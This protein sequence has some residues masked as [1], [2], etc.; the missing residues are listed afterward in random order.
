[1]YACKPKFG[2]S[3]AGPFRFFFS[4]PFSFPFPLP[5]YFRYFSLFMSFLSALKKIMLI[6]NKAWKWGHDQFQVLLPILPPILHQKRIRF[7]LDYL[8]QNAVDVQNRYSRAK[9]YILALLTAYQ[10]FSSERIKYALFSW[11]GFHEQHYT[12][13]VCYISSLRHV[14][15]FL[16]FFLLSEKANTHR[17]W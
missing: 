8:C 11:F 13:C 7:F 12:S 2:L 4:C 5:F 10:E 9:R 17:V 16:S 1:M 6:V 14:F 3:F 15:F